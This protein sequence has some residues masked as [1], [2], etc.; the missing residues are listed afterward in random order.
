M[1]A[2][3]HYRQQTMSQGPFWGLTNA[4]RG[5]TKPPVEAGQISSYDCKHLFAQPGDAVA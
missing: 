4:F 3:A 1:E 2:F 5:L